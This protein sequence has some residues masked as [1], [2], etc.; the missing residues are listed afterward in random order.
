MVL[1]EMQHGVPGELFAARA[2]CEKLG[3]PFDMTSKAMQRMNHAG[4][5][6]SVQG[7]YGGYQVNRDLST[8][9]LGEL[10]E[11]V[12]GASA[13]ADCLQKGHVCKLAGRC[14]IRKAVKGLDARVKDLMAGVSVLEL[15]G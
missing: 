6:R 9:S 14:T 3:I 5:L 12:I 8:L 1:G 2:L 7:K 11:V 10:T 13:V 15:V 4:I